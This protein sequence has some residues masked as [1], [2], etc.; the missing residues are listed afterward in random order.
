MKPAKI[1]F[2]RKHDEFEF[3]GS[4]EDSEGAFGAKRRLSLFMGDDE[5]N[6]SQCRLQREPKISFGVH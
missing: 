5:D 2:L 1:L 3:V 6:F 4:R